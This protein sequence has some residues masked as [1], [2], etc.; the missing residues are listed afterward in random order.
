MSVR[1]LAREAGVSPASV[2]RIEHGRVSAT[3]TLERILRS[4]GYVLELD[5][6]PDRVVPLTR[7]DLRSLSY[8]RLVAAKLLENPQAVI[9]KAHSNLARMRRV[10]TTGRSSRYLEAWNRLLD[11][12]ECELVTALLD[13]SEQARDLRQASPFAGVLTPV[14]RAQVYSEP[15]TARAS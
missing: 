9:A 6:V 11:G 2:D 8:H 10:D 12:T 5:A 15:G 4:I 7:E 13:H 3:A 1:A 14:E